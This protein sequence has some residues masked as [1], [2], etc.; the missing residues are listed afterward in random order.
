MN[1]KVFFAV[2]LG[3]L[4]S[5]GVFAEESAPVYTMDEVVVTSSRFEELKRNMT[6]NVTIISKEEIDQSSAKDLGELIAEQSIGQVQKYPG[7]LTSVG[8]RGFRTEAHGNDLMGKVLV[9]L[10]GRRAG[11][12]NLAKISVGD[13]ERVEIVRGP[14]SVQYGSAAIGGVINV[15]TAKGSGD[16]GLYLAQELGSNEYSRSTLGAGGKIE[17]LDF[18]GSISLS[19][20]DD[21][22]T[23]SGATYHNTAF[24]DQKEAALNIGY[25]FMPG[26]RLGVSYI[27]F[28]VDHAGSA[29]YLSKNDLDN[30]SEKENYSTDVVY[31]GRTADRRFSWMA[32]YF[33]GRDME[34]AFDPAASNPGGGDDGIPYETDTDHKGAQAQFTF[35]N[36]VFRATAGVDWV[37]YEET[38]TEYAP[39]LSEYDNLAQFLLLNGYLFNRRLVLSAGFRYDAY[40]LTSQGGVG[41]AQEKQDADDF[42]KN[43]GVAWH[44]VDGVKVRASYGE[45]FKMPSAKELAAD[46]SVVTQDGTTHYVGNPDLKPEESRNYEI[47]VDLVYS[48]MNSSLTW[49]TT[50]FKN[51]IQLATID[52]NSS[53]VNLGSATLSGVEGNLSYSFLPFDDIWMFSPYASCVYMTELKDD[54]TGARLLSTPKWNSTVG[55]KLTDQRG[56][57]GTFNLAYT[58]ETDIKDY[59]TSW[60]GPVVRKGG[61]AV[62]NLSLAKR[63]QID[64]QKN[65]RAV[66][67]KG[68]VN[69]LFDRDYQYVKGYPMPGINFLVGLRVDI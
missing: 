23:G 13:V 20:M 63:F 42:L 5:R 39:Y 69:N 1:K 7:T 54:E 17:N 37:N 53:W 66:T 45:G 18:S 28:T 40:D 48:R 55:L 12:G 33:S 4:S 26:H 35:N 38:Q 59:E 24:D 21:Y 25:E 60:A 19:E 46:Y 30:Y 61:F 41:S 3:L 43:F 11:T 32:R 44:A 62:A 16:P 34:T 22:K 64:E 52:G 68:E 67:L 57:Y 2:M 29:N 14:A 31:D 36:D 56:F 6:S 9:L 65:G 8:M 15:I 10:N 51:M 47:G 49:F 58:G 27:N 50:D